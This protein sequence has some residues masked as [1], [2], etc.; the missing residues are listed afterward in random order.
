LGHDWCSRGRHGNT[1]EAKSESTVANLSQQVANQAQVVTEQR[2]VVV[3]PAEPLVTAAANNNYQSPLYQTVLEELEAT[4][5]ETLLSQ[6]RCSFLQNELDAI[7]HE[8]AMEVQALQQ[9]LQDVNYQLRTQIADH[10]S[11]TKSPNQDDAVLALQGQVERANKKVLSVTDQL[12]RQQGL[13]EAA[14]SEVMALKGRLQSLWRGPKRPMNNSNVNSQTSC[15]SQWMI[16]KRPLVVVVATIIIIATC[17]A[18][19]SREEEE[20]ANSSLVDCPPATCARR[21]VY[22]PPR[23]R[24]RRFGND[25]WGPRWT[26]WTGGCWRRV[27]SSAMSPWRDWP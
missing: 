9:Q 16:W 10:E 25:R 11:T 15:T 26:L 20:A 12:L 21:W 24:R 22:D 27:R 23:P 13:A 18:D 8:R 19:G 2:P 5:S 4:K 6:Q 3:V 1:R 17:A 7:S 14:K